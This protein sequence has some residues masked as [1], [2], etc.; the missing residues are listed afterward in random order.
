MMKSLLTGKVWKYL[1]GVWYGPLKTLCLID[2]YFSWCI[3]IHLSQFQVI[4]VQTCTN[5]VHSILRH[6]RI[7][8]SPM[9]LATLVWRNKEAI[10]N[11][12]WTLIIIITNSLQNL[13]HIWASL[14][15]VNID[16]SNL[17]SVVFYQTI[18]LT[19]DDLLNAK[20]WPNCSYF[21]D[22]SSKCLNDFLKLECNVTLNLLNYGIQ[23]NISTYSTSQCLFLLMNHP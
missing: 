3:W 21:S 2:W 13:G 11:W 19:T 22:I 23:R 4:P 20:A 18:M 15:C 14:E 12:H 5:C 10:R 1:T 16:F 8:F 9:I 17:L 7:I 6:L